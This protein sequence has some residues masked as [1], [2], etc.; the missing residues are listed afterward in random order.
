MI[1]DVL[2][3]VRIFALILSFI[4]LALSVLPCSDDENC[5]QEKV[6]LAA[7][8][9]DHDHEEDFCTPFCVCSCCGSVG[10]VLA[11]PFFDIKQSYGDKTPKLI[12]PYQSAFISSYNFSFWQP[13]KV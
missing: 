10:F 3:S 9:S 13:P 6:E 11:V 12:T 2:L 1:R 8:H 5:N 7:D 4:V